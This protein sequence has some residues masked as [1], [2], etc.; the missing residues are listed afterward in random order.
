MIRESNEACSGGVECF[1]DSTEVIGLR[2]KRG[3]KREVDRGVE[4]FVLRVFG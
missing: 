1:A 2:R 3:K 4:G